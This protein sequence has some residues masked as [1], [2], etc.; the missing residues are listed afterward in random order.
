[1]G[2]SYDRIVGVYQ[3]IEVND[4]INWIIGVIVQM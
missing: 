2:S 3:F 4:T 1:M